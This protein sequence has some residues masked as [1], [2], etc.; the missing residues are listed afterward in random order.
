MATFIVN[1]C[2][3][4]GHRQTFNGDQRGIAILL[5]FDLDNFGRHFI[6]ASGGLFLLSETFENT[7][8]T[9]LPEEFSGKLDK[10]I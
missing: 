6:L 7:A 1:G 3:K 4:G 9:R 8:K 5:R 2:T 10:I